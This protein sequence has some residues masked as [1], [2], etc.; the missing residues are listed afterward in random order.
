MALSAW[1][2]SK[3]TKLAGIFQGFKILL[4]VSVISTLTD[5]QDIIYIYNDL[6]MGHD[7]N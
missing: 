7:S 1:H 3:T 5:L 6:I 2:F 4:C